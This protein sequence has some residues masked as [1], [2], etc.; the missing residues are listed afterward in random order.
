M[1]RLRRT[2]CA[3]LSCATLFAHAAVEQITTAWPTNVGP[4]NPHLY[5]PNQMFA[6]SMV[7]EPLVKYQADG[8][9]IPWLAERW[10][11]SADGKVWTFVLRPGVT[12]SNGEPFNAEAA[13]A[14]FHAVLANRQRH[15]WLELANQIVDVQAIAPQT[16]QITLKSAYYPFLQELALPRPFRFI[17]PSQFKAQGSHLGIQQ[18]IGTGP[19]VLKSTKLNQYDVL[20]RNE[21][22]WGRKPALRQITVKVIP[23]ATTRAVA[24]ETGEIDLLYGNEG[25]L[26]LD[27]F[28]RFSQTPGYRTQLSAPVETVVLALNSAQ[29]PTDE[30]AVREALNHAVNKPALIAHTLYG[31]QQVADTLFAPSVPYADIGLT[32]RRYDPQQARTRLEQ[33]GWQLPAGKTIREKQGKPLRIELAFVGTDALSKSM[34]EI[35]QGDMRQIGVDITLVAEE[36]SS[37]FARQRDGRFGMIFNHT[38]GAPYDPH[39][40][41]SSMR[42]PSH[43]DFQAQRG[44]PDKAQIDRLI[45]EVLTTSDEQQRRT[46]YRDILTRLHRQA[47]YLPISYVST[48][49]VAKPALGPIP[50][51]A[52]A[53][54]IPFEQITPEAP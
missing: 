27:T 36:E 48:M 14:N 54:E 49:V 38:W 28:A 11:H 52:V 6:Q 26:P 10:H 40:F 32:P 34:A 30:L 9:V 41:M 19:W 43:A 5:A 53:S 2:L 8:S 31:T 12:F 51:A 46:L 24:V 33:A 23:D 29:A 25:L 4:L 3:L 39:A 20:V 17:A 45:G 15:A 18:P 1:S 21:H 50:Y 37:I 42:V 16:L 47:V 22:Y 44:L 13:A 7:Y 35:I